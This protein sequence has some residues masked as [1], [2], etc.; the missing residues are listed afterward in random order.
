MADIQV[1]QV[2]TVKS[3]LPPASDGSDAFTLYSMEVSDEL[4]RPFEIGAAL[5]TEGDIDSQMESLLGKGMTLSIQLPD[6]SKRHF[7]GLVS[8]IVYAESIGRRVRYEAV[9]R[10][11]IWFLKHSS[12]NRVF[13]NKSVPDILKE[14]FQEHGQSAK[15]KLTGSYKPREYCVQYG[16]TDF[17]FVSRLMEEEGIYY[18]F[19]YS[20]SKH[21]LVLVDDVNSHDTF[22]GYEE[23]L[24]YPPGDDITGRK[25]HIS[26]WACLYQAE[27]TAVVKQSYNYETPSTDLKGRSVISRTHD[28][29]DGELYE[30][31]ALY[32]EAKLGEDAARIRV[33]EKQSVHKVLRGGGNVMGAC[34]G[35]TF[36]LK[37][38]EVDAQNG[39]YLITGS[40]IQFLNNDLTSGMGGQ[41]ASFNCNFKAIPE[42]VPFRPARITPKGVV[43]GPQTA[44]VVGPKGDEIYTDSLGRV[45]VQFHWDREGKTDENSSCM[46]RVSTAIAGSSWG[47][48]SIPRIGQEVIVDFLEGDPDQPIIV[49]SVYNEENKVPYSLP[50]NQT[51]SGFK[52]RST[53]GKEGSGKPK[54]FNEIRFEDK[55]DNEEIF[56]QAEKDFKRVVKNN[57]VLEVG[58]QSKDVKDGVGN[59]TIEIYN[60]RTVTLKK[61]G[62]EGNDKL[63]IEKGNREVTL[64]KG[65][66]KTKIKAGSDDLNVKKKIT[67]EAGDEFV[68]KVGQ[69]KL[70]MKSSGEITI[71]GMNVSIKDKGATKIDAKMDV[72]I[73]GGMN[74]KVEGGLNIELKG[75]VGAKV[76]GGA[77]LDLKG[78]AMAKLKGGITMIG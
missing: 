24:Y 58:L 77:N 18:F 11:W 76:D 3:T 45:K 23:I 35:Y 67:Y 66:R 30:Y 38:A 7:H 26:Q 43:R 8:Q 28:L 51:Q 72:G 69:A 36:E 75:G 27:S 5:L 60:N 78:G 39:K 10:P 46:V 56:I 61:D 48:V 34:T 17:D 53:D 71:E 64:K 13:Q 16:E 73:K 54:N 33:E 47:M 29:S 6:E 40:S 2:G 41:G 59:Q 22:S 62:E 52:S 68:L 63:T 49:G 15:N 14:I 20:E 4:G 42:K 57:D 55:K 32:K 9:L 50:D 31:G 65:D 1:I 25:D 70:T 12:D 74:A 44:V 21:D 19:E 37:Q